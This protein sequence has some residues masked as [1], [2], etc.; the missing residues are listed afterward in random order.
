MH[1][2]TILWDWNGTLL[3]DVWLCHAIANGLLRKRNLPEQ[4]LEQYRQR[5]DFPVIRYYE[6]AGF[7]FDRES[8]EA[9]SVHFITEY[10]ARR[11]ECALFENAREVLETLADNHTLAILSA[12]KQNTLE[13]LI[14]HHG[15]NPYFKAIQGHTDIYANGKEAS[16]RILMEQLQVDPKTTLM[17]GD[18]LHDLEIAQHIGVDCV[19]VAHGHQD[20]QR[21]HASGTRVV[22]NLSEIF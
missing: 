6:R 18:T 13:S 17:I 8:F 9:L 15:L 7:C 12:Y 22:N 19:L 14:E 1:Y 4:T 11:H 21:L 16:A 3:N 2:E 10:E 20:A 5:F